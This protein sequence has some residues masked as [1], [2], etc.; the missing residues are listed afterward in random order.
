M[1]G[2][3]ETDD[4]EPGARQLRRLGDGCRL[5][6][7]PEVR[8]SSLVPRTSSHARVESAGMSM[9]KGTSCGLG[10]FLR[11]PCGVGEA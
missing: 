7:F 11:R 5:E 1:L 6:D 3:H 9:V 4:L 10:L 8:F 2:E